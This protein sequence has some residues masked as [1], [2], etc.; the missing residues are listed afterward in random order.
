MWQTSINLTS[1][2][3]GWIAEVVFQYIPSANESELMA[4]IAQKRAN[5]ERRVFTDRVEA[6]KWL[7]ERLLRL[8]PFDLPDDVKQGGE[9]YH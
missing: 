3:N 7:S 9:T 8:E 6:V 2:H 4:Q 5:I 1:V